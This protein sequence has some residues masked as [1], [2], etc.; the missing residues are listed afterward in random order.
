MTNLHE[1]PGERAGVLHL[2]VKRRSDR[3]MNYFLASYFLLGIVLAFFYD[4]W[5]IAFGVGGLSLLAF[6]SAKTLLPNSSIYQ[7]VLSVA[8]GVFM[9]QF[10][11][12]MH[13]LFEMHF[14][15]F[16][17]SAVLITYQ[18]WKLQIPMLIL[19]FVHH[20]FFSYLQNSGVDNVYFTQLD[21]FGLQAFVIHILLTAAIFFIC[22]LWAYQL[23]KFNDNYIVQAIQMAELQKEAQLSN[24]RRQHADK[25]DELNT[26]LRLQAKELAF[27]NTELEQ[28]AYVASHDLQEPLRTITSF[29]DLLKKRYNNHIDDKGKQYIQF[30]MDGAQRMRQVIIELLEFSRIGKAGDHR[31]EVNLQQMV[32][33]ISGFCQKQIEDQ[34]AQILYDNLPN[35]RTFKAPIRQVFQNLIANGLK[36]QKPGEKP[37]IHITHTETENQWQFSISDNGIGIKKEHFDTI[38]I[39][40]RR[41]HAKEEYAGTGMG[42]CITKKA[43]EYLGGEIWVESEEGK[44]STFNFTIL[45]K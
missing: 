5:L 26:I 33:E 10:I 29:M 31:E 42:L 15:A 19:V 43:V 8:L 45:K 34:G 13:G 41:L 35:V 38:F 37:E 2:E 6:Y 1:Q 40:F 39:I 18:K 12:Q 11:Y 24:E 17:G 25:L 23:K 44:G 3:L 36:Y 30:A 27:S 20:A 4:T 16:I 22:G 9:A 28:F 32:E 21:H 14:F 7:Y